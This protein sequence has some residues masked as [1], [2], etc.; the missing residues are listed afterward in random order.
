M[1]GSCAS[2]T[3]LETTSFLYDGDGNLVKK[4]LPD[5]NKTLY[6][7]GLYEVDKTP[8]GAVKRTV[9]YYAAAGAMRINTVGGSNS[10]YYLLKDHLGSASVVTNATGTV[11]GEPRYYP[12]GETRFT[13]GTILQRLSKSEIMSP[14]PGLFTKILHPRHTS[15]ICVSYNNIVICEKELTMNMI[16][17]K[18]ILLALIVALGLAS[19]PI[20]SASASGLDHQAPAMQSQR[21]ITKERLEKI[22]AHQLRLYEKLGKTDEFIEKIQKLIDRA[23]AN[24]K[25]VSAVQAALDAFADAW[26]DAKPIYESMNGIVNSHQGFDENGKVTDLEKAKETVK[27]MQEKFR[28]IKAVMDGTG[29]ALREALKAFREA[30]PRP[31][32]SPTP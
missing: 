8:G 19:L 6:I 16:F 9:T 28:E 3:V 7:G 27:S 17:K 18:T 32:K 13:S 15:I 11:V 10:V 29:Q 31:Q 20:L 23:V 24:G 12:Y 1:S 25:D 14:K 4:T 2:G 21:E 5:S 22:W 30:N 26:K